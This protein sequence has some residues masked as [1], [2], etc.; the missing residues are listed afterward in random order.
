MKTLLSA[1]LGSV[2]GIGVYLLMIGGQTEWAVSYG[3]GMVL[4]TNCLFS[5][6]EL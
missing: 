4:F 6:M 3:I 5:G 2:V 1:V